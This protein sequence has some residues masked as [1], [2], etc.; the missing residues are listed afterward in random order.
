[1]YAPSGLSW[2]SHRF[3]LCD[4]QSNTCRRSCKGKRVCYL[5]KCIEIIFDSYV[6]CSVYISGKIALKKNNNLTKQS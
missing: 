6:V 2:K 5:R 3:R 1:M 4:P